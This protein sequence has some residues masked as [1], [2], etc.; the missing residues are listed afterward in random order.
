[1]AASLARAVKL[2]ETVGTAAEAA[3]V[4]VKAVDSLADAASAVAGVLDSKR[5]IKF[6][7]TNKTKKRLTFLGHHMD[8]GELNKYTSTI[9]P[10]RIAEGYVS[11]KFGWFGVKGA[12]IYQWGDNE[13]ERMCFFLENPVKGGNKSG[14]KYYWDVK[15]SMH[16]YYCDVPTT[17][18]GLE[19]GGTINGW[20]TIKCIV[21]G[22]NHA[23]GMFVLET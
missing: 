12:L 13:K 14:I 2:A 8:C 18:G 6:L 22:G 5:S 21:S 4:L 23:G 17:M 10:G 3:G 20:F 1:M 15:E 11:S 16:W 9:E 19:G 7:I